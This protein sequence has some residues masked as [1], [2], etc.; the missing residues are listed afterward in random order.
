V[1]NESKK[2]EAESNCSAFGVIY[3]S[4]STNSWFKADVKEAMSSNEDL[5]YPHEASD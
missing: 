4:T 2:P 1:A 3:N 5:M